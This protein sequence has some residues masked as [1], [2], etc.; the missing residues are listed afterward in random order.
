MSLITDNAR[1]KTVNRLF[2]AHFC[3]LTM[4]NLSVKHRLYHRFSRK[5]EPL[6]QS[7]QQMKRKPK[8]S[9]KHSMSV[10]LIK[11][12]CHG[13]PLFALLT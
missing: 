9:I 12:W 11:M 6:Y 3:D 2:W 10:I 7:L 8:Q 4:W 5:E 1:H 13:P